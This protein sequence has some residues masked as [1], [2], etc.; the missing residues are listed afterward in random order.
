MPALVVEGERVYY[1]LMLG[2]AAALRLMRRDQAHFRQVFDALLLHVDKARLG[3]QYIQDQKEPP[4]T[5]YL[6]ALSALVARPKD[7]WAA[8]PNPSLDDQGRLG[9]EVSWRMANRSACLSDS[10]SWAWCRL[11]QAV[12]GTRH[13]SR[14]AGDA[15][16]RLLDVEEGTKEA[17]CPACRSTN[18]LRQTTETQARYATKRRPGSDL[19]G[20]C[21]ALLFPNCQFCA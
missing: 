6:W 18:W 3:E 7:L 4:F 11:A 17:Y 19:A 15:C 16:D 9:G 10:V 21:V 12:H 5:D 8:R 14:R 2:E 1:D 13:V 20:R